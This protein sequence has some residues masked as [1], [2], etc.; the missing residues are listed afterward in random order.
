M[1][2]GSTAYQERWVLLPALRHCTAYGR[3]FCRN[4]RSRRL[5]VCSLPV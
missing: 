1:P 5:G 2:H 4:F 3:W